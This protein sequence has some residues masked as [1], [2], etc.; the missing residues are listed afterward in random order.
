MTEYLRNRYEVVR[1]MG[2]PQSALFAFL[3]FVTGLAANSL[4]ELYATEKASSSVTDLI[5]SN[6]PVVDVDYVFVYG[7]LLLVVVIIA[8]CLWRPRDLPFALA[9]LGMFFLIRAVFVSL[10]HLGPYP[11]HSDLDFQSKIILSVFGGGDYFFSGHT[12][13]P[14]LMAL[15]FWREIRLRLLFLAWSVFFAVIVLLGHLHYSIDVLS[16]YFITYSIYAL[17]I[18]LFPLEYA[19]ALSAA[20]L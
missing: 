19:L 1:T 13:A 16:A 10:T 20:I 17:T 14:F 2:Y 7:A 11:L 5:L 9:A 18:K 3:F 8:L 12:G 6:V 15:V 4:A